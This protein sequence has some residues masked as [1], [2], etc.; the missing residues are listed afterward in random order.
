MSKQAAQWRAGPISAFDAHRE[1]ERQA[2]SEAS[3]A[4]LSALTGDALDAAIMQTIFANHATPPEPSF[5]VLAGQVGAGTARSIPLLSQTHAGG[6]VTLSME[7][8]QALHP[9]FLEA[10]FRSSAN[11]QRELAESSARWL[12]AALRHGRENR[13]S[14]LLEGAFASPDAALAVARQFTESGY[15]VHVA[16]VAVRADESLLASTSTALRQLREHHSPRLVSPREHAATLDGTRTLIAAA[17]LDPA[18]RRVSVIGRDGSFVFD[19]LRSANDDAITEAERVWALAGAERMTALESAQWLGELR[20][21]TEFAHTLRPLPAPIRH[22]LIDL[23][24]MAFHRVV[25]ELPVPTESTVQRLQ[26]RR[27]QEALRELTGGVDRQASPDV[28]TPFPQPER[29]I[30]TLSR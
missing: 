6:A 28:A 30:G 4:S 27:H 25:P 5:I 23:H 12:H 26:Q 14:M 9:R 13:Y 15:T 2:H 20:R 1:T 17:A 29:S 7:D 16:V 22:A 24:E 10:S 21:I 3:S 8:L 18:V 19:E 11:G